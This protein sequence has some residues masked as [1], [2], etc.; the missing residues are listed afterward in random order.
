MSI[1]DLRKDYMQGSLHEND[2]PKD[3]L[4]FFNLWFEQ[5]LHAELPE[6]NAMTLSTVGLDGRPA[7]RIVLIK[8]V[9]PEGF[10]FF[11]NYESRKGKELA[12][13]PNASLLFYWA[14]L[15]RQ[16]RIEGVVHKVSPEKSDQ[17]YHSRPLGSRLGAWASPQSQV[18]PN[19]QALEELVVHVQDEKGENPDRPPHWG[20]YCLRPHY[21][22]FWQGR[23]SRLHD[24]LAYSLQE[25]V[26]LRSRLAP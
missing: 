10:T 23:R 12:N 19:R 20:G 6:P 25:G 24:R 17:Y 18:L 14:E 26:W 22:E 5:A 21:F 8:G 2:A 7:S 11:T 15:E 1:A 9:E 4:V 13:N 16:I 3:P